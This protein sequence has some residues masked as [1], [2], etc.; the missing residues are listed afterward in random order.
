MAET[1]YHLK[2]KV[3]YYS[4]KINH[5]CTEEKQNNELDQMVNSICTTQDGNESLLKVFAEAEEIKPGL[6]GV[7]WKKMLVTGIISLRIR[8]TTVR[9]QK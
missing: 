2:S 3:E 8:T 4:R 5:L 9:L 1:L 7:V 6:G